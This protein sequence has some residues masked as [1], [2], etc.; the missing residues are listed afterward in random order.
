MMKYSGGH[1]L[2]RRNSCTALRTRPPRGEGDLMAAPSRQPRVRRLSFK[3]H[4][5]TEAPHAT[6]EGGGGVGPKVQVTGACTHTT[7]LGSPPSLR[8][9][10]TTCLGSDPSLRVSTILKRWNSH[11]ERRLSDSRT[12]QD[13]AALDTPPA[14]RKLSSCFGKR[15][16]GGGRRANEC[17]ILEPSEMIVIDYPDVQLMR[18][19]Q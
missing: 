6:A 14:S 9:S 7:C 8:V 18:P 11:R 13:P 19:G 3:E 1:R 17:L 5:Q 2:R 12:T 16:G 10:T 15:S 4:S